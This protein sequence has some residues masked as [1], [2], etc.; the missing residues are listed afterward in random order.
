MKCALHS[1]ACLIPALALVA[2]PARGQSHPVYEPGDVSDTYVKQAEECLAF[3]EQQVRDMITEKAGFLEIKCANCTAG[4]QGGQL[5]WSTDAPDQ[6][7]CAYCGH[8]YPSEKYPMDRVYEH[9]SPTGQIQSYPY[10]DGPD[11]FHHFFQAK[12]DY[13]ARYYWA[14]MAYNCALAWW[15]TRDARYA[16]RAVV[17]LHRMAEIY[18]GLPIHGLSDYSFRGPMWAGN[19]PPFPYLSQK[20]GSTWFYGEI[21]VDM[22][23]AYD[24]LYDSEEFTRL[25]AETNVDVRELVKTD[26]IEAMADFTL[27]F[28]RHISNMTPSWAR[29]LISAG[30]IVDRPDYVH[31]GVN[32]LRRT[33]NEMFL[34]DGVWSEA[35][36]SYHRQ[37][38]N[39]IRSAFTSAHGYSD[40]PGY[41][42]PPTGERLDDYDPSTSELFLQ[43]VLTAMDPLAYPDGFYACMHDTWAGD[44]TTPSTQPES[45]L[46]W[47]MGH[48]VLESE[49]GPLA[50]EAQLHFSGSHGHAHQDPLNLT[51]WAYGHE[52][53]SDLGYT[54]TKYRRYTASAAAHNLVIVDETPASYGSR[55]VPWAGTLR[56][57]HTGQLCQAVCVDMAGPPSYAVCST[58]QRSTVLVNRPDAPAY[59]VDFFDVHGG[60]Q[61][62]WLMRGSADHDQTADANVPLQPLEYSLL[63]PGRK[64]VPYINEGGFDLVAEDAAN[65]SEEPGEG[66]RLQFNPYGLIR[67]LR[68]AVGLE[69]FVATFAYVEPDKPE[70]EL[71]VLSAADSEYYL[72]TAP[73][74]KR[75]NRDSDRV[76]QVRQPLVIVRRRGEEGLQSR[77]TALLWPYEQ[78]AGLGAFSTLTC[79]GEIVGAQVVFGD[80]TDLVIAPLQKPM[81]PIALDQFGLLTDAAFAIVRLQQGRPIAAEMHDG[82]LL[83]LGDF[84]LEAATSVTGDIAQASGGLEGSTAVQ[85]STTRDPGDWPAG[86]PIHVT[87]ADGAYSLMHLDRL[88]TD[89]DA[90]TMHVSEPPDFSVDGDETHFHFYPI[91]T[92]PGHPS[93]TMYS[94]TSWSEKEGN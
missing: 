76:D 30:W 56:T 26:L 32:I 22:L 93:F 29:R 77:F 48:A 54:H 64:L 19:E 1:L 8:V 13:H 82:T 10:Y 5:E 37:T 70:M 4:S 24:I 52:L 36:V 63:G 57:W 3:T 75:C 15:K 28:E 72:A 50:A 83:Q 66:A 89:G 14:N 80:Y 34:A 60:S 11:G 9:L 43:K 90:I 92:A 65:A 78:E 58:Y 59:V 74:I 16:R 35:A 25:S 2:I 17:I 44:R 73:S 55:E 12:I 20:L 79:A 27:T 23:Q 40:P 88:E 94:T 67:D 47:G 38:A 69:H 51:Y 18:P 87:H 6:L 71:H 91:R 62:D 45:V 41:T 85:V 86:T 21:D 81:Q 39:G 61:H 84:V 7:T 68:K 33:L 53:V 31:E 46:L 42:W 49:T